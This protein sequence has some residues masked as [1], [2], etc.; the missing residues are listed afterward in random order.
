MERFER[1]IAGLRKLLE[2]APAK[3]AKNPALAGEVERVQQ[4]LAELEYERAVFA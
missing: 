1:Q 2:E 4:K 3:V